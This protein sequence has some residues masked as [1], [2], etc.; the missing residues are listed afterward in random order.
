MSCLRSQVDITEDIGKE[1]E[2]VQ[3]S[4]CYKYLSA[5]GNHW[6]RCDW[7]SPELLAL[8]LK[9]VPGI[10]KKTI[11]LV[12][13]GFVWT[14]QHSKRVKLKIVV[15]VQETLPIY[16]IFRAIFPHT[17]RRLLM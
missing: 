6:A 15:Q 17:T 11:N 10:T 7:E 8:C 16:M 12:D 4:E 9:K 2:L 13:A 1:V 14:E 5:N 3:C